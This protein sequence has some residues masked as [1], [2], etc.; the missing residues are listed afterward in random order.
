MSLATRCTL[1]CVLRSFLVLPKL[2]G[3][4]AGLKT[5]TRVNAK[6]GLRLS[7][8]SAISWRTA[9]PKECPHAYEAKPGKRAITATY[10]LS[11][12]STLRGGKP[13]AIRASSRKSCGLKGSVPRTDVNALSP[14]TSTKMAEFTLACATRRSPKSLA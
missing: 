9:P 7:K 14:F 3:E 13:K 5:S 11:T 6:F 1:N 8:V 12:S 10:S 4:P 2:N